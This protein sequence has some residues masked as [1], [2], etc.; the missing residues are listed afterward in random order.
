MQNQYPKDR[1]VPEEYPAPER[2]AGC[3]PA[4]HQLLH[5]CRC[6]ESRARRFPTNQH[7]RVRSASPVL[8][9][10]PGAVQGWT[11]EHADHFRCRRHDEPLF[12]RSIPGE[13]AYFPPHLSTLSTLTPLHGR[14]TSIHASLLFHLFS[15]E[16]QQQLAHLLGSLLLPQKGS[17]IFGHQLGSEEEGLGKQIGKWAHTPESWRAMME[18]TF[19]N[20]GWKG[21]VDVEAELREAPESFT[22]IGM[23]T[24]LL[25]WTV[26][27]L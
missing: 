27:L 15:R 7:Y 8:G 4:R 12:P 20:L 23:G 21:G 6:A 3:T 1:R 11:S 26:E 18:Q 10:R 16:E 13:P 9:A 17:V 24:H 25:Y 14:L 2:E 22:T 5:G 19:E